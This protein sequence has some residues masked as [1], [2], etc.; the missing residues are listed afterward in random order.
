MGWEKAGIVN[1]RCYIP[2]QG[3]W[4]PHESIKSAWEVVEK[5][6]DDLM[7]IEYEKGLWVVAFWRGPDNG[8]A[9]EEWS[10]ETAPLAICRAAVAAVARPVSRTPAP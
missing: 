7:W 10:A 5:L 9:V 4:E 1:G 8:G 3:Y 2:C 6:R